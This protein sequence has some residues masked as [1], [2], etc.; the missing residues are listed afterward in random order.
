MTSLKILSFFFYDFCATTTSTYSSK[1]NTIAVQCQ[2]MVQCHDDTVVVRVPLGFG[3]PKPET[4]A[5][6]SLWVW[7]LTVAKLKFYVLTRERIL[8]QHSRTL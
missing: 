3:V 6:R 4:C 1:D 5:Q 7:E 2:M 8:I